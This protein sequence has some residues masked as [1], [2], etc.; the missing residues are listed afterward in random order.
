MVMNMT[1]DFTFEGVE[2]KIDK[3]FKFVMMD[4][5]KVEIIKTEC[6][7]ENVDDDEL[8]FI[9]EETEHRGDELEIERFEIYTKEHHIIIRFKFENHSDVP[10]LIDYYVEESDL[11][12][13]DD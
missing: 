12:V 8:E 2:Y 4:D 11:Y 13:F 7:D 5:K 3:G 10:E 6:Y 9:L 1:Y